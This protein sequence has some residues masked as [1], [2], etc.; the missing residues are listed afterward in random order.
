MKVENVLL[1]SLLSIGLLIIST[2][3]DIDDE[4]IKINEDINTHLNE[5]QIKNPIPI[6]MYDNLEKYSEEYK[7]PK[8]IIY[9]IAFLETRYRGPFDWKYRPDKTSSAGALG[10]MQIMPSTANLI[11]KEKVS[12]IKIKT[13]IDF[14]IETSAKLLKR[15]YD[16]YG[17][18]KVVC[19][20]YNTGKPIINGYAIFCVSNKDYRSN[21]I[22]P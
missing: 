1:V 8:H 19:G 6:E 22:L 7:I 3:S 15:L 13:D 18:W 14:N 9:N 5:I 10:P 11:C 2:S 17:D 16:K 12:L 4:D 21:W 20:C